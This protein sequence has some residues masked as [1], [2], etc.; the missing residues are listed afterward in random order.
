MLSELHKTEPAW[1]P[2]A[3]ER[4]RRYKMIRLP[5][6][7]SIESQLLQAKPQLMQRYRDE[8]LFQAVCAKCLATSGRIDWTIPQVGLI[9]QVAR[10]VSIDLHRRRKPREP[11][12]GQAESVNPAAQGCEPWEIASADE[13]AQ[14]LSQAVARLSEPYRSTI[15]ARYYTGQT[16]AEIASSLKLSVETIQS[17]LKRARKRLRDDALLAKLFGE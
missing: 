17:R 15:T 7:P 6:L 11:V 13:L 3:L 14:V 4:V 9:R 16:P 5:D 8:D 2:R 10:T 12:W 1:R